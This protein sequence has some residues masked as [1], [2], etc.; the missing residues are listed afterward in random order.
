MNTEN[1]ST[2][3]YGVNYIINNAEYTVIDMQEDRQNLPEDAY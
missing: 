2:E 1:P 3:M